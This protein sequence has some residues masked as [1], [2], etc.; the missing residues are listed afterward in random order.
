M[1]FYNR[2]DEL[3][4]LSDIR[5]RSHNY[6]QMTMVFGRRRIGKTRL[7]LKSL[8]N[9]FFLY[10]FV[11]RKNESLLCDEYIG[12][13]K[14]KLNIPVYGSISKFRDIFSIIIDAS[15][16]EPINLVIDE[17]QEFQTVNPSIYSELQ[18]IWDRNKDVSRLNLIL[19]GSV[20]SLMKKIF[21]HAKEPLF[22]RLTERIHLQPFNIEVLKRILFEH[23]PEATN[24][25]LLSFY[26]L[27]GG[28]ARYV[29]HFS[30]KFKFTLKEMLEEIF[31]PNSLLIDEGRNQLIEEFGKDYTTYFSVLSLIAS[32]KTTRQSI[33][34]ILLKDVGG[35]LEKLEKGFNIIKKLKPVFAK[36]GSRTMKYFIDDNFLNFWFRFIYKYRSAIEIQ[37]YDYVKNIVVRDF[38]TYSGRFLEKYFTGKLALTANYSEI[39]S[40]W[41][42]GNKNE[43]DIVAVNDQEK[44]ILIGEVKMK[45]EKI[46]LERLK[47][48]SQKIRDKFQSYKF[49]YKGFS[50][51][52][53]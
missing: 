19:C 37:N 48:K 46:N 42:K 1:K 43:I 34:S 50:L 21:E 28:V 12:Q 27:T 25:D 23:K 6:A 4:L 41:E 14:E 47:E 7:I 2:N 5:L 35:Y 18:D 24:Y 20:Y 36:P 40:Y 52:D 17:F 15:K 45:K 10:F 29:E 16:R 30:D 44:Q 38:E 33:E 13:V 31:R 32:G 11:T 51:E 53:M 39:G 26:I 3:L 22:G 49:E 9:E 8:E